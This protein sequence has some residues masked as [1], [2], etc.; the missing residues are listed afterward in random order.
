MKK[1]ISIITSGDYDDYHIEAVFEN[2]ELAEEYVAKRNTCGDEVTL[3]TWEFC[4]D[5]FAANKDKEVVWEAAI[6]KDRRRKSW[7]TQKINPYGSNYYNELIDKLHE[8]SIAYVSYVLANSEAEA[9]GK[10]SELIRMK[11]N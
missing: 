4:D 9:L 7:A 1:Q 11:E 2:Q 10:L 3:E 6:Y 5:I 8:S